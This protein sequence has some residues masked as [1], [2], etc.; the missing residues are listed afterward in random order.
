[1]NPEVLLLA[2]ATTR[3][4]LETIKIPVVV[5]PYVVTILLCSLSQSSAHPP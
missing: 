2:I 3:T 4:I 1:M 5:V